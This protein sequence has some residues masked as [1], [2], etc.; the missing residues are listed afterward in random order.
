MTK[1]LSRRLTLRTLRPPRILPPSSPLSADQQKVLER[2]RVDI[3]DL[4]HG[5]SNRSIEAAIAQALIEEQR[6]A[7]AAGDPCASRAPI[8]VLNIYHERFARYRAAMG[9]PPDDP[10]SMLQF[11]INYFDELGEL[12]AQL[13]ARI[14]TLHTQVVSLKETLTRNKQNLRAT[15]QM[16]STGLFIE[17]QPPR[18]HFAENRR[19]IE[20]VK[21]A[22]FYRPETESLIQKIEEVTAAVAEASR[23]SR[24]IIKAP[25]PLSVPPEQRLAKVVD[26]AQFQ[27]EEMIRE[28]HSHITPPHSLKFSVI[29]KTPKRPPKRLVP[30]E[31]KS[32]RVINLS[33]RFAGDRRKMAEYKEQAS[34]AIPDPEVQ[35][36]FGIL[37]QLRRDRRDS[38]EQL[39]DATQ[40]HSDEQANMQ[41]KVKR[42]KRMAA[43]KK[44]E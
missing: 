32:L 23:C 30:R 8:A 41:N 44:D 29:P 15:R 10:R 19:F 37:E 33:R 16:L 12:P 31:W 24:T 9:Q 22:E 26:F 40:R 5:M 39:D 13:D 18:I 7:T 27:V 35:G 11:T 20:K 38:Q 28:V 17:F 2:L 43:A 42:L 3:E 36:I 1:R 34:L 25:K 6:R 14:E 4:K 21:K